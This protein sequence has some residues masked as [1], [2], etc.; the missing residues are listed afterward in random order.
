MFIYPFFATFLAKD[1][2]VNKYDTSSLKIL[3]CAGDK[4]SCDIEE[5]VKNQLQCDFYDQYAM[6]ET[7]LTIL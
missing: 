6:T 3:S 1:D 5:R 7:G 2:E 4:L